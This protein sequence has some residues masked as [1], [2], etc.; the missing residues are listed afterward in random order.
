MAS[1]PHFSVQHINKKLMNNDS[2][3]CVQKVAMK[4]SKMRTVFKTGEGQS[5]LVM[6]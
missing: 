6:L 3:S 4:M 1:I 5:D 2:L